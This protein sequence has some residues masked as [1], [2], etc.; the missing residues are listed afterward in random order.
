MF[1]TRLATV[2]QVCRT[3]LIRSNVLSIFQFLTLGAYPWAKGHQKREMTY[4]SPR[5]HP[6]RAN[7]GRDMRYQ[8]LSVFGSWGLTPGPKLTK[9]GDDLADSEVYHL[10]LQNFIAL[11]QPTPEISLTKHPADTHKKTNKQTVNDITTTCLSA[12]ADNK[13]VRQMSGLAYIPKCR[14]PIADHRETQIVYNTGRH[15]PCGGMF[16][17]AHTVR[18]GRTI[19]RTGLTTV[20]RVIDFSIFDLGGLPLGQRSPIGEMT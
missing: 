12:C 15:R 3:G 6:D 5:F 13:Q 4:Y 17:T 19:C 18:N 10:I 11:R 1:L 2:G 20:E 8:F 7:D 9:R 16:F 14:S